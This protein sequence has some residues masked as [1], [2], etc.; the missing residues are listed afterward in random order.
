MADK[1]SISKVATL[2]IIQS[3]I[4]ATGWES[5]DIAPNHSIPDN[6]EQKGQ[7]SAGLDISDLI[8]EH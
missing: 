3:S 4:M 8:D 5:A 7:L 2:L 6:K 1:K